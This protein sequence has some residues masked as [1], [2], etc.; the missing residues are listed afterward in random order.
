MYSGVSRK[1]NGEI[2]SGRERE[3]DKRREREGQVSTVAPDSV[4]S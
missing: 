4:K 2:L 1:Q 3:R